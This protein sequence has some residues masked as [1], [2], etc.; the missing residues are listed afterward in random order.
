MERILTQLLDWRMQFEDYKTLILTG[1]TAK[2]R[3]NVIRQ[4]AAKN[5]ESMVHVN[6]KNNAKIR[7]YMNT[8]PAGR[9]AYRFL[10]K[11]VMEMIMP[12]DTAVVLENADS[13]EPEAFR[14]Y[15]EHLFADRKSVV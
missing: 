3:M 13:L 14:D 15:A 4:F 7:E 11:S 8:N 1:S 2:D 5:F 9:D 6:V 10:E 12:I